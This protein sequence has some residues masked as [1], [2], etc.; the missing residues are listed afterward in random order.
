M[1][2]LDA[3]QLATLRTAINSEVDA[4]FVSYRT[5]GQTPLMTAW[6][7]RPHASVKAWDA[8]ADWQSIANAISFAQYT[9]SAAQTPTDIAGLCKLL[10]IL[11]KLT[12]QQNM[13]LAHR[14]TLNAR[15]TGNI[16]ALL[17]TVTDIQSGN[18]GALRQPGGTSGVNAANQLVR[19]AKRGEVVF[20]G[21]DVVK[22]TV[23]A[24]ML[25]REGDITD[26]DISAALSLP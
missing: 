24:K 9:P 8:A 13:L 23:T 12:V 7:N 10:T 5:N 21:S 22:G 2:T 3:A 11:I 15:D 20:G 1:S 18:N 14:D 19:P 4:E 17:D 16:D 25:T 6:L 26:S